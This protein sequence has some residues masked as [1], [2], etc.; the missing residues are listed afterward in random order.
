MAN[1]LTQNGGHLSAQVHLTPH[2]TRFPLWCPQL[3]LMYV[4]YSV[5]GTTYTTK[6]G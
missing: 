1:K 3:N 4:M 6:H 5:Q 2:L